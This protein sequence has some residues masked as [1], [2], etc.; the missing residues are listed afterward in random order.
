MN[1]RSK[2]SLDLGALASGGLKGAVLASYLYDSSVAAREQTDRYWTAFN[3]GNEYEVRGLPSLRASDTFRRETGLISIG[4][5]YELDEHPRSVGHAEFRN[6]AYNIYSAGKDTPLK[7]A[8]RERDS[9]LHELLESGV[10]DVGDYTNDDFYQAMR[11]SFPNGFHWF[12]STW[13]ETFVPISDGAVFRLTSKQPHKNGVFYDVEGDR[14]YPESDSL[15]YFNLSGFNLFNCETLVGRIKGD[16]QLIGLYIEKN[17]T[18]V[19]KMPTGPWQ[20][21]T[22]GRSKGI[23]LNSDYH[24]V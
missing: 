24:L 11:N 16:G 5:F 22:F 2:D 6:K 23:L 19:T 3:R 1:G 18:D 4:K 12:E 20:Y 21:R 9:K 10:V 15:S 13:G 7:Q 14:G 17:P 8:R